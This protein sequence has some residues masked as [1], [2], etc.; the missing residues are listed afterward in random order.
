MSQGQREQL[1]TRGLATRHLE[2]GDEISLEGQIRQ[3]AVLTTVDDETDY[4]DDNQQIQET[5][6][7]R[8]RR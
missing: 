3:K 7:F 4:A 8:D 5:G 1:P 6:V 2:R